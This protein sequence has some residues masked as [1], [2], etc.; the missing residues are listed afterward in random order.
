MAQSQVKRHPLELVKTPISPKGG[1]GLILLDNCHMTSLLDAYVAPL[2]VDTCMLLSSRYLIHASNNNIYPMDCFVCIKGGEILFSYKLADNI[3]DPGNWILIRSK[4]CV[5]FMIVN[6][7]AIF[8][9]LA[10]QNNQRCPK[11]IRLLDDIIG[12]VL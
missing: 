6:T 9:L 5:D 4:D 2:R 3:I 8:P 1:F 7:E 11:R 12:Y 10:D